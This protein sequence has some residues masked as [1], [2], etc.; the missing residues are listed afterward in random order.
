MEINTI[1]VM[2]PYK[3]QEK[4]LQLY[5]QHHHDKVSELVQLINFKAKKMM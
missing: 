1:I 2:T 3:Q 4:M 5:L